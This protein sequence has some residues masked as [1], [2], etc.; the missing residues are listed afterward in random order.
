MQ[1]ELIWSVYGCLFMLLSL[2]LKSLLTALNV[3][4]SRNYIYVCLAHAKLIFMSVGVPIY[5]E[6]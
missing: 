3:P 5:V 2:I 6:I 1:V 4:I